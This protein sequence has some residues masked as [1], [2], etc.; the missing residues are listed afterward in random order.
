M[1]SEIGAYRPTY[2]HLRLMFNGS[3]DGQ[4][5]IPDDDILIIPD[6][7][8]DQEQNRNEDDLMPFERIDRTPPTRRPRQPTFLQP[9][10]G[11]SPEYHRARA[12]LRDEFRERR[13]HRLRDLLIQLSPTTFTNPRGR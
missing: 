13:L 12:M 2:F 5:T 10:F 1:D 3:G 4:W 7:M 6:S 9:Q 11:E 8:T